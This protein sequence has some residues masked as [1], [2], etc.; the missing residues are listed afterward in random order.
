[1]GVKPLIYYSDN[2]KFIFAS[3]L[4]A[5]MQ[6]PIERNIDQQS[7]YHYFQF[8]YIPDPWTIYSNVNK[9]SPGNYLLIDL[10]KIL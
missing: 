1:M 4:K 8:N 5:I 3:E 9:L 10:K 2:D 6:F 7:L